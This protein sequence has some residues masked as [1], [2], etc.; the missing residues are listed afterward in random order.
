M[1]S[2]AHYRLSATVPR[3]LALPLSSNGWSAAAVCCEDDC[4]HCFLSVTPTRFILNSS[5]LQFTS[6]VVAGFNYNFANFRIFSA[7]NMKLAQKMGSQIINHELEKN[8]QLQFFII[9]LC[10]HFS[11]CTGP[12]TIFQRN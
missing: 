5:S 11:P 9:H 12:L 8:K 4:V 7:I 3:I 6:D 1:Y 2:D 10:T